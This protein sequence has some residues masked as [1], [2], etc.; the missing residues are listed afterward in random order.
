MV[1]R[2]SG[3]GGREGRPG[4]LF[5]VLVDALTRGTVPLPLEYCEPVFPGR[6]IPALVEIP[7]SDRRSW[8]P[9]VG[10][11]ARAR[12]AREAPRGWAAQGFRR[13]MGGP[14]VPV[15]GVRPGWDP[16]MLAEP[17]GWPAAGRPRRRSRRGGHNRR[18]PSAAPGAQARWSGWLSWASSG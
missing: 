14:V 5:G 1:C 15:L 12:Y 13:P 6:L 8:T 16:R 7:V 17:G 9:V 10:R 11:V 4:V 3:A 18:E 2:G